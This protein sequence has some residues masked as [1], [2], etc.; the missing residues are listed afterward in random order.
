MPNIVSSL[1]LIEM[2]NTFN[3][4]IGIMG[5][6]R[7]ISSLTG[8]GVS[9]L[10]GLLSVKYRHK[11]LLMTG[12]ILVVISSTGFLV[13][14]TFTLMIIFYSLLGIGVS[15]IGPMNTTVL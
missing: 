8:I 7:T 9:L 6:L 4:P 2:A 14:T 12:M 5:Q 3:K 1:L 11:S 15:T 13:S 10:M